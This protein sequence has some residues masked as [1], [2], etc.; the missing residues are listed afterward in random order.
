MIFTNEYVVM[1]GNIVCHSGT[2]EQCHKWVDDRKAWLKG[3]KKAADFCGHFLVG[4]KDLMVT[5]KSLM[6]NK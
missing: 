1:S 5:K 3:N 6:E 4:R 2:K